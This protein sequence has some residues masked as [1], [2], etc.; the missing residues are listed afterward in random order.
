MG[1][2]FV[3]GRAGSG[4]SYYCLNQINKKLT[5]DKNNK[6]IMLVPDQYTF[7]TEKKLLEYIGE[8]ALLRAEVL[9]FK[10]MATRV[11]DKCG[12]R[13]INVIE[14]SGK[15]MLIY[16]LLKDKGEEL[17]YFNRISKQQGFV[18]IVSKSITEFKKYNISEEILKE[19]ELEIENKDL[20]EKISDLV[21]I[22]ETFNES[23]HK[24]YIDSEDILSI[25]AK[26]L[27]ECDLYDDAEIWVDEFTTFTPQQLEVLKVLAKQCKNVNITLCSDG[28]IQFT[29]GETDIFDV[30]KNTENR[31]LKMMQENNISYKEPV[32]LNKKNIYRFKDSKELGHIEKYFFNYPFKIYKDDCKDIR[33]Y[34]AN[35]NY[36]EIEWVAQDILKLVR[37][38]GYR[39]KDIAV[40]CREID[41]YDKITSVI[42]NEYNIPYFLDKKREILSN[43]LVVLIIS[44]LEILVTNWSY[45]SV[46]KYVKSGLITLETNFID[47]LENYILANGIK[48]Y[49][50]TRDLLTSQDQELTQEEIEI[51]EYMEEIRRPIINLYNKI[52]GDVTVR[53]YCTA[54]YEFLL[55]IN[56]FETMDKWLDDFNNKGMQDKIKEYTQV[57]AIVMDMLDQAVEVLGDEVVD[58]KTFSKILISGFEEKEIGVIPMALDQVNIGDIARIKGRDVKALYIVGANDGV[59]PSANK[60]EGILSDEDRIELKSMGIELAS[61]TRSRVFEEQFMVYTAL[62]IPSNYLMI[63]YPMADFEGK[64]L[65]PSIIIPRLKKI[66]PRLKEESEIFNNNLFNDKYHNITAPVPTFNELIEALRREY[67]KEEIEPYWVET[68]KWFEENEE[69]KDRTKIIFNG[70]NYTNLV[71]K[72]PREK[73]KRLYSNDNGRLMFS[74][75][76]IEKYAQCPFSYYVQYGLKAKDRKVYEFTAPDLGSFMH[77]I[78][79][80]FTNKIRKENILWGDLTKDKCAEIVNELVNSKL[81]NETNSILNSNKKYQ[82]FSER[83]KKTITKSVTVISEQMRKG[84]FDI[85]KSEFDFGDFKDSNPIKLELPSKETVYLKG[86]VDRIDKVD[87]NGETYIRIVDYKSGSKSFDLNEL[88]YGLQIQLLVYLDAILKNSEQILKT[89][90]MPG[91]ILYFK[92][93]NPIIK[94]KKALTEEEIQVEV[95]KKLKMDG[96]LLKNVELVKSMDRDMET[97]SLIIPAAFKK[98]GDITS[99]SSVVTESQFELLRKYVNDKMIE[100]CEEMLSGEVKI[101]P[102]KSSKVTYC[103]Y[104][105]YSSICQFDTSI[106]DNKYKIILKKKKDDLWN[107]MSNKVKVEEDE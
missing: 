62:T 26:K 33:L 77:D 3:F 99:T 22:Y 72:I 2:R 43:P 57:P 59:L 40:V 70:L 63:T 30:I 95:L 97:Y 51:F 34:K 49:K 36:S 17:Q 7:Q 100:I 107:A 82:Y 48:G 29:E 46:F 11:F 32:N 73:I 8:K 81:K 4:K 52:K 44:A 20:K 18:G 87:L 75:S 94:S 89:Q 50:W 79:D 69:F 76:R 103:D 90:C 85:F 56:A 37:D 21:S 91:G 58:L 68:F 5:N 27:K 101:E 102:C 10:R 53:K 15:N 23:L 39:Y 66:L 83:F 80:Q 41:S 74:V 61:D 78:L 31:I 14:D 67:E 86:R 65:R 98:D 64:S 28:E 38:K 104:C 19:K 92:I 84:E 24:G 93:D 42:F 6:L 12:G 35:N 71:E 16:K 55:E 25:L 45:E 105:D 60:D 13:A 47:K 88:Y 9:S 1:I 54:L 96:L 106:K